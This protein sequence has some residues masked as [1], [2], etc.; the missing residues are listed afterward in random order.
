M[1]NVE[2]ISLIS[3][4]QFIVPYNTIPS[5]ESQLVVMELGKILNYHY[6]LL[7]VDL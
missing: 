4:M 3:Y 6:L 1:D 2:E 5:I 7:E